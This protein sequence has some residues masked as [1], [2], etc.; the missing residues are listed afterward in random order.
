MSSYR[1]YWL[2]HK[3]RI[4]RGEWIEADD[5]DD[6]HRR[7]VELCQEGDADRIQVWQAARPVDDVDCR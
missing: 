2:D 3:N 5:D 1:V 7:A 4:T 6:A